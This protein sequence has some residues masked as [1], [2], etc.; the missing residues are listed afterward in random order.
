MQQNFNRINKVNWCN[1]C[2]YEFLDDCYRIDLID[3][4]SYPTLDHRKILHMIFLVR[5][6]AK[7]RWE[8]DQ[9]IPS[10]RTVTL[11]LPLGGKGIHFRSIYLAW[12]ISRFRYFI[13]VDLPCSQGARVFVIFAPFAFLRYLLSSWKLGPDVS[14]GGTSLWFASCCFLDAVTSIGCHRDSYW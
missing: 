2:D 13:Y 12:W 14:K 1:A 3:F 6:L 8:D 9:H 7:D 11:F 5:V 10:Y 4:S